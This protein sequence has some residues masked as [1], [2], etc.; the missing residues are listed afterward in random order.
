MGPYLLHQVQVYI[1]HYHPIRCNL[2]D[3]ENTVSETVSNWQGVMDHNAFSIQKAYLKIRGCNTR[4]QW[5][6]IISR[7]RASP[8]SVF[9]IWM[10]SHRRLSTLDRLARWGLSVDKV[11]KLCGEQEESHQHLFVDFPISRSFRSGV[12]NSRL[13]DQPASELAQEVQRVAKIAKKRILAAQTH[14]VV[15]SEIMYQIWRLRCLA[16]YQN[17]IRPLE[18]VQREVLFHAATRLPAKSM[19]L[20]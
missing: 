2:D 6:Y 8:R 10:L 1:Y 9:M 16:V 13:N 19:L 4:V 15:W 14:V 7:N 11:C 20:I 12:M 3:E 18:A 5:Y 17:L